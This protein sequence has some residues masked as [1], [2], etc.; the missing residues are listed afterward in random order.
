MDF[1]EIPTKFAPAKK[2]SR[3]EIERQS[4]FFRDPRILKEFA[5]A[6][7]NILLILNQNRQIVLANKILSGVLEMKDPSS[8]LGLRPG[9]ALKC[10]HAF[11]SEGGCG[12]TEFCQT[13][14]AVRAIL[15]SQRGDA[16]IQEC[17][18][19]QERNIGS[20]DLRIAATPLKVNGEQ[21][22]VFGVTDITDEKRRGALERIFFHDVLNTA[23]GLQGYMEMLGDVGEEERAEVTAFARQLVGT[24]I[25]EIK[26]QRELSDAERGDIAL[27]SVTIESGKFLTG[28]IELYRM[29]IVAESRTL[30]L[31]ADSAGVTFNLDERL[32]HRVVG[33]MIKNALEASKRGET[34]TVGCRAAGQQ[35][36]FWVHNKGCMPRDVQ[37]QIFQRSFSTKGTGRGLGTYSIKLLG[38]KYLG[39]SV[40]FTST[41]DGG[42]TFRISLPM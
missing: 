27:D 40:A 6:V 4:R 2:S 7:P 3:E 41:L 14:G 15:T 37:L 17:R 25:E 5:D 29:H 39:G 12:T 23:S 20:L 21:F 9:E 24:L 32:L 16:N 35:I 30:E 36:E 18:I 38:E 28:L 26:S 34:V 19:M 11:E 8:L 1:Q 42:T 10:A 33:N 13:C 31:A 22:T